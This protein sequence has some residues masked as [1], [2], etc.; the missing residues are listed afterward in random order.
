MYSLEHCH[1]TAGMSSLNFQQTLVAIDIIVLGNCYIGMLCLS[2]NFFYNDNAPSDNAQP[3]NFKF[4]QK[5]FSLRRKI[6]FLS[7]CSHKILTVAYK[8]IK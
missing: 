8:V 5:M 1:Q 4:L 3:I 7:H 2:Y 6:I